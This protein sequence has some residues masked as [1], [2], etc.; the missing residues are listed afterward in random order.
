MSGSSEIRLLPKGR[1]AGSQEWSQHQQG[2][3]RQGAGPSIWTQWAELGAGN[4]VHQQSQTRQFMKQV[5]GG[6]LRTKVDRMRD[7]IRMYIIQGVQ[8]GDK[9]PT[10]QVQGPSKEQGWRPAHLQHS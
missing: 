9:L 10:A 8:P 4:K 7:K 6:Q 5:L 2:P 3:H 1:W